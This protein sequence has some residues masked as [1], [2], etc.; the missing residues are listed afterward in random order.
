MDPRAKAEAIRL[1]RSGRDLVPSIIEG[2]FRTWPCEGPPTCVDGRCRDCEAYVA[3]AP[4]V[5][6][7]DQF[8]AAVGTRVLGSWKEPPGTYD[9]FG[10]CWCHG[11]SVDDAVDIITSL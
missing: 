8:R 9:S 6:A 3:L 10:G 1:L 11:H 5:R 2:V 7:L 4:E